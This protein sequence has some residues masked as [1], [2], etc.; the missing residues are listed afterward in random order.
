MRC[1]GAVIMKGLWVWP[2]GSKAQ[3]KVIRKMR[4]ETHL[5]SILS[6]L[7]KSKDGLS[8]AQVDDILAS[9]SQWATLWH[10]R[11]LMAMGF[12]EYRV[13]FFGDPGRYLMTEVGRDALQMI[14]GQPSQSKGVQ[15]APL[16]H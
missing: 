11:E 1:L 3:R 7:A 6:A 2:D 10:L 14:L 8:N 5:V 16:A 15:A 9:N 4:E 13:E 12:V